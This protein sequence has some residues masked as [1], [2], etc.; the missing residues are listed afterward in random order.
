MFNRLAETEIPYFET[1]I[2]TESSPL[3]IS[4]AKHLQ[5]IGAKFYGA[6]WC[7]H[8]HEQKEVLV[9]D[10]GY[11]PFIEYKNSLLKEPN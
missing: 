3:A 4:L 7:S 6:F 10:K 5:S 9:E 2:T 8:C 1:E 11:M